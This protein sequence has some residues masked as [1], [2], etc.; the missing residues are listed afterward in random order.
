[1]EVSTPN[2]K[3]EVPDVKVKKVKVYD[4][5]SHKKMISAR[6]DN[7]RKSKSPRNINS[8][9]QV[10]VTMVP[11][12]KLNSQKSSSRLSSN[13]TSSISNL[14]KSTKSRSRSKNS[15]VNAPKSMFKMSKLP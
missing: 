4:P 2:F 7:R 9:L 3:Q 13:R 10:Q 15:K 12:Q 5:E 14:Q 1:M 11:N 8:N 6:G